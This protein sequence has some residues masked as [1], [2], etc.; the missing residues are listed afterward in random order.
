MNIE[1]EI[2]DVFHLSFGYSVFVGKFSG[3]EP[4]QI[5]NNYTADLIVDGNVYLEDMPIGGRM[6]GISPD[7]QIGIST[8]KIVD[9][10]S[11]FIRDR[12][13]YLLFREIR[14]PEIIPLP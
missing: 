1:M 5:K 11:R 13:C 10:T 12:D 9:V 8:V 2:F 6:M 4:R 14:T 7:G 3:E